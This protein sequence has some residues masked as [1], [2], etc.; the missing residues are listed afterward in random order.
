MSIILYTFL[1]LKPGILFYYWISYQYNLKVHILDLHTHKRIPFPWSRF[2]SRG[3]I[4]SSQVG[5]LPFLPRRSRIFGFPGYG[6]VA[7]GC[8]AQPGKSRTTRSSKTQNLLCLTFPL[9]N[10]SPSWAS[11]VYRNTLSSGCPPKEGFHKMSDAQCDSRR[12]GLPG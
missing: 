2:L 1:T 3:H 10:R 5:E 12:A 6:R 9:A 8:F 11:P 7:G 4:P